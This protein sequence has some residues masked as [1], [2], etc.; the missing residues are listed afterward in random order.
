MSRGL[1]KIQWSQ[2]FGPSLSQED[3]KSLLQAKT[4]T[5]KPQVIEE[6]PKCPHRVAPFEKSLIK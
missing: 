6:Y 1:L 5:Q 2:P 3:L 4:V